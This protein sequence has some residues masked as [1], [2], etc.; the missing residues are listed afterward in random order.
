MQKNRQLAVLN[1]QIHILA[2]PNGSGKTSL[3][4][5]ILLPNF[6]RENEF[7]NADEIVKNLSPE[8]PAKS[9]ID[10][11]RLMLNR[12]DFLVAEGKSFAFETTLSARTYLRFINK[13]REAGY[14]VNLI[15]LA[16]ENENLAIN[17]VETRVRKGGHNIETPIIHRR[18]ARG[19]KNL[20]DYLQVVDTAAIYEASGLE[21]NEIAKK[22]DGQLT[23]SNQNLWNKLKQNA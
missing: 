14:R 18:F 16:L 21:L 15:F 1:K 2:G 4:R 6:L 5:V 12:L 19:L 10:A 13:A 9:Q 7:V 23:I 20:P 17:R 22:I 11:G 3:A 8:N